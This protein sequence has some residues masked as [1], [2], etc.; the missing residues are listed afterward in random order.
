MASI[1]LGGGGGGK[2]AVDAHIPLIPFIDLLLCCVMFLLVTAV[3]NQLAR[4]DLSQQVP[5]E[6]AVDEVDEERIGLIVQLTGEGYV[7]STSAG[8]SVAIPRAADAYDAEALA[9]QLGQFRQ[10]LPAETPLNIAPEDGVVYEHVV[11]VMDVA[12]GVGYG[13]MSLGGV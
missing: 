2:K 13:A 4:H 3:W 1:D 7:V 11:E 5:G 9:A 12:A 10:R 6:R 8:D